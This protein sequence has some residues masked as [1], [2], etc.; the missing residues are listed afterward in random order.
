MS[1]I[2][3]DLPT[4]RIQVLLQ[5]QEFYLGYKMVAKIGW[6]R[7]TSLF[8]Y[9]NT[10]SLKKVLLC[11]WIHK[12]RTIWLNK[13]STNFLHSPGSMH[14]QD[15]FHLV[16]SFLSLHSSPLWQDI[17]PRRLDAMRVD[18]L[19]I[20]HAYYS[21]RSKM[22]GAYCIG[23]IRLSTD[24]EFVAYRFKTRYWTSL[25]SKFQVCILCLNFSIHI[26][27]QQTNVGSADFTMLFF[28]IANCIRLIGLRLH[29]RFPPYL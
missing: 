28:S 4:K 20:L 5:P 18:F 3:T 17:S 29:K 22:L 8:C 19:S 12:R 10:P 1:I 13:C 14:F 27:V 21:R 24:L 9:I 26:C 11:T 7:F 6:H 23:A 25:L 2:I 16:Q 15:P